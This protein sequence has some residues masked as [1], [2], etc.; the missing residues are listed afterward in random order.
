[1]QSCKDLRVTFCSDLSWSAHVDRILEKTYRSLYFIKRTFPPKSTPTHIKKSLYLSMIL[2]LL[3]YASQIWRPLLL[4]DIIALERLQK[5]ATK[6]ILNYSPIDYKARLI[7]LNILPLM[8]RLELNDIM[9]Y[10][11]SK[12]N[13]DSHFNI[14]NFITPC[15]SSEISTRS[16]TAGKLKHNSVS[17]NSQRHFYFNRL[18]CLWNFCPPLNLNFS[19]STTKSTLITFMFSHFHHHFNPNNPCTFHLVCPCNSCF[20]NP[21]TP[22]SLF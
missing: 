13:P 7:G 10:V 6:Y 1:M 3:T 15:S 14:N 8:Y 17:T 9:L 18:P 22:S 21:P 12:K 16:Q 19:T 5:R 4:K 11:T 20:S 2:P